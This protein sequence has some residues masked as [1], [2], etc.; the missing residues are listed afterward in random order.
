M[1]DTP[2]F[3]PCRG[4]RRAHDTPEHATSDARSGGPPAD[5]ALYAA[6]GELVRARRRLELRGIALALVLGWLASGCLVFETPLFG[7]E[8]QLARVQE[9]AEAF[10]A[11]LRWGRVEEAS[12]LLHPDSRSEFLAH[13]QV[14]GEEIRFTEFEV[15]AVQMGAEPGEAFVSVAFRAYRLPG[16][17]EVAMRDLQRWERADGRW[18]LRLD[19]DR[20]LGRSQVR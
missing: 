20:Y 5:A 9:A 17:E 7:E 4:V 18:Y 10:A 3:P 14:L 19:V 2:A 16:I 8:K 6:G 1:R 11:F 15:G 13:R 12:A